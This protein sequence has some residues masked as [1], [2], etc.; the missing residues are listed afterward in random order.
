MNMAQGNA[1]VLLVKADG[2]LILQQR[3]NKPGIT[4]SGLIA[5][6]G[7]HIE[8]G[9]EPVDAAVREINEE[10]NLKLM[11]SDLEFFGKYRKTKAVHGEDWDVYFFIAKGINEAG[12][13]VFEGRGYTIVKSPKELYGLKTTILLQQVL[14][15]YFKSEL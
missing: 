14:A 7:G 3:D 9:E 10:T 12:L 4:N 15:D 6:F 8:P 2:S 13:E 11:Q 1:E 5:S